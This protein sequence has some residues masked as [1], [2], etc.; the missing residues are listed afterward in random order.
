MSTATPQH[1]YRA[2]GSETKAVG[3]FNVSVT[4]SRSQL[5]SYRGDLDMR[6]QRHNV[7]DHHD[8]CRFDKGMQLY[9]TTKATKLN[10]RI[11]L[12]ALL[13]EAARYNSCASCPR[14][15]PRLLQN[16]NNHRHDYHHNNQKRLHHRRLRSITL[17]MD[18]WMDSDD[19]RYVECLTFIAKHHIFPKTNFIICT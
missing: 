13:S 9:R 3:A 11:F 18:R 1:K 7:A 8:E 2:M 5:P 12:S 15:S 16:N 6:Q 14:N 19:D 4:F 17:K 10:H